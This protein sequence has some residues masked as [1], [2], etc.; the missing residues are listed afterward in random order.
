MQMTQPKSRMTWWTFQA[1]VSPYL[2]VAPFAILF[3]TFM[4]YPLGRSLVLSFQKSAGPSQMQY[5]GFDNYL[6]L[7][8]D[9]QFWKAVRNTV[10]YATCF[11]SIQLP[12]ALLLA[13]LLNHP[14]VRFRNFFRFGFFSTHLVG[15]AFVAVIFNIVLGGRTG[16]VNQLRFK[17]LGNVEPIGFL[18]DSKW[19]M[20][21]LILIGLWL[22]VGYAMVYFLAALQGVDRELYEAADVDGASKVQQFWHV[23]VPGIRPVAAFL[24]LVG[25]VGA[26]QLFELP[27]VLF[28]GAGPDQRALTIVMYLYQSA[29]E[30][31]NLGYASACGW[32]LVL[33]VASVTIL[34]LVLNKR[35]AA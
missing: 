18:T 14:K 31:G 5:V 11:L 4:A 6:F 23:T 8:K 33:M 13:I 16:L 22:S 29:F 34:Q 21:C 3:L 30:Q 17:F 26:L 27:Y 24:L 2:F 1:K 28:S 32:A 19:T 25:T 15:S 10:L 20:P 9:P 7:A 12:T 35:R